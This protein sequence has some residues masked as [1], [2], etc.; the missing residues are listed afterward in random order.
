M[1]Y[2]L[3]GIIYKFFSFGRLGAVQEH[4]HLALFGPDHHRLATHAAHHVKRVHRPA[5]KGKL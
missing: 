1:V 5:A 3:S 4:L 2:I